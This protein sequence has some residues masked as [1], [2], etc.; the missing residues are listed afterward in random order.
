MRRLIAV[1]FG[2]VVALVP[3]P[4]RAWSAWGR[5]GYGDPPGWC[6]NVSDMW[7]TSVVTNDPLVASNPERDT[8]YGFHADP[9]Y[10]DWYGY[11][12]GDFRGAPGDTSGWVKLLHET[13]PHHYHWTIGD[14]GWAVHGHVKA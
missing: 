12:Y 11:F 2:C 13:Y 14:F 9:G 6:T 10:D 8:F 3:L 7:T 5:S 4:V 1:L